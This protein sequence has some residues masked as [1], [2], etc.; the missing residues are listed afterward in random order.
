MSE[1]G[2]LTPSQSGGIIN[3][4]SRWIDSACPEG[5]YPPY[6]GRSV[7]QRMGPTSTIGNTDI[8]RHGNRNTNRDG[9]RNTDTNIVANGN[10]DTLADTNRNTI[11]NR[12]TRKKSVTTP[13]FYWLNPRPYSEKAQKKLAISAL[14]SVFAS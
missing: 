6:F 12:K 8:N 4:V 13:Y 11:A 5:R 10:T 3:P 14:F 2:H 9:D 7:V 1:R